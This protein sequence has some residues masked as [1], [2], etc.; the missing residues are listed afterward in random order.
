MTF[1]HRSTTQPSGFFKAENTGKVEK[2]MAADLVVLDADPAVDVRN[3]SGVAYTIRAG[4][5][6]Y[7]S[8]NR[9]QQS[10]VK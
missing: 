2:G 9:K 3:F 6:I 4:K 10:S 5:L 7:S 1:W 8:A